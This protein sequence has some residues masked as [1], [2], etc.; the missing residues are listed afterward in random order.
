[1]KYQKRTFKSEWALCCRKR[2]SINPRSDTRDTNK[3]SC[4]MSC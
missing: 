4:S 1:M 3:V 2:D